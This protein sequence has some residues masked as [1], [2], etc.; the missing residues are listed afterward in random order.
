MGYSLTQCMIP[1]NCDLV[2]IKQI[3]AEQD[4]QTQSI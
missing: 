2:R 1:A 3:T 4:E